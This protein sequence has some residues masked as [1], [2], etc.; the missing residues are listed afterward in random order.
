MDREAV[1]RNFFQD[2]ISQNEVGLGRWFREDAVI[3]WHCT[4]EQF[5]AEEYIR[6]NCEYPGRWN[7][8]IERV[9]QGKDTADLILVRCYAHHP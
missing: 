7:G 1:I 8:T 9:E 5:S 4:N 3:R 6:A 2:V